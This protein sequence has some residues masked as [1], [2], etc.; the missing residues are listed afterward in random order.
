MPKGKNPMLGSGQVK[1][2]GPLALKL[3]A[4]TVDGLGGT[5]RIQWRTQ[6]QK[7][8]PATGQTILYKIPSGDDW[9][10]VVV[11][12][13]VEGKAAL[14]RIYMPGQ[15]VMEIHSIE[16]SAEGRVGKAWDFSEVR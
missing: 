3:R 12:V 5:G 16:W 13:P 8:F 4:R 9:Q 15:K 14:V 11:F 2:E 10:D 1:L 7:D 6:E